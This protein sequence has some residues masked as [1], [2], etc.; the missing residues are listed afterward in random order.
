[1]AALEV[2]WTDSDSCSILCTRCGKGI[3]L[4]RDD[5]QYLPNPFKIKCGCGDITPLE[6]ERRR[7]VRTPVELTGTL[8]TAITHEFLGTL[9][10][11]DLSSQGVGFITP[12]PDLKVGET[13]TITFVLDDAERTCIEEDI[14]VW[15]AHIGHIAGAEFVTPELDPFA[16]DVYLMTLPVSSHQFEESA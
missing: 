12:F 1:M 13:Y 8:Y 11:I 14:V 4:R 3:H 2:K 15:H 16:L 10:I 5:Y 7:E 9:Q 6:L